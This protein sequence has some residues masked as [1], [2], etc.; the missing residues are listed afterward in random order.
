MD[1]VQ[2]W[3]EVVPL[4]Y[5]L[6]RFM[7]YD[8]IL[9]LLLGELMVS[10]SCQSY[11]QESSSTTE[12]IPIY[13]LRGFD[14]TRKLGKRFYSSKPGGVGNYSLCNPCKL[15][16]GEGTQAKILKTFHICPPRHPTRLLSSF[17]SFWNPI[18][19]KLWVNYI[20][21]ASGNFYVTR[22]NGLSDHEFPPLWKSD[23]LADTVLVLIVDL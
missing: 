3:S 19:R 12:G 15:Y 20:F 18:N 6:L 14:F 11:T 7:T 23:H 10:C 5:W 17:C 16:F 22:Y 13:H 9:I 21:E 4:W 8:E 2:R 1:N